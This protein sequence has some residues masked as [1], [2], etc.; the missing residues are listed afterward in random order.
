MIECAGR[1]VPM[2]ASR[3]GPTARFGQRCVAA[4]AGPTAAGNTRRQHTAAAH[5][6][7]TLVHPH[8]CAHTHLRTLQPPCQR[9]SRE[10]TEHHC[11]DG[12]DAR[13]REL[14]AGQSWVSHVVS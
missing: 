9:L 8:T 10:A 2:W 3:C 1:C 14:Q 12:A 4:F 11:V 6:I 13:T 7:G 5:S